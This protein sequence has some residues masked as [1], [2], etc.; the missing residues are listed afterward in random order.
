M[1]T[2][3]FMVSAIAL[4]VGS[5]TI[6]QI[7]SFPLAYRHCFVPVRMAIC[8]HIVDV[9]AWYAKTAFVLARGELER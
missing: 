9:R 4:L 5:I 6:E 2:T 7:L 8:A 3:L 1:I